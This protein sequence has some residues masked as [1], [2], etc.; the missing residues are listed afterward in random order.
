MITTI[1]KR[2]AMDGPCMNKDLMTNLRVRPK[3][4]QGTHI[5][6]PVTHNT[7]AT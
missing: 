4:I 3:A 7:R 1:T 2:L 5:G 6:A